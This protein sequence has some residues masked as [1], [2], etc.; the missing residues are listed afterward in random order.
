MADIER[1][2]IQSHVKLS[3]K[4]HYSSHVT[5][6]NTR[7]QPPK[8]CTS[9][10]YLT[11]SQM[12]KNMAHKAKQGIIKSAKESV[13]MI[14]M[15]SG[16]SSCLHMI[17]GTPVWSPVA[18]LA[19]HFVYDL[20]GAPSSYSIGPYSFSICWNRKNRQSFQ[21]TN[22]EYQASFRILHGKECRSQSRKWL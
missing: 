14:T 22:H 4:I 5:S 20:P 3:I 7:R 9:P 6:H 18:I 17:H 11:I 8:W 16:A 1:R 19:A 13:E 21:I 10:T 12:G 15:G 2:G